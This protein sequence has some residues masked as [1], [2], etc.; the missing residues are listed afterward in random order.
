MSLA[1][2]TACL[3]KA[4]KPIQDVTHVDVPPLFIRSR[5]RGVSYYWGFQNVLPKRATEHIVKENTNTVVKNEFVAA[6]DP[7]RN[8]S[9]WKNRR[10][11]KLVF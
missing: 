1:C 5:S 11:Q 2:I 10:V 6:F 4:E 9:R 8:F 3:D 7:N